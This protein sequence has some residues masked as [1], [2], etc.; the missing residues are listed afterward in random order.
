MFLRKFV[1][2]SPQ[3]PTLHLSVSSFLAICCS[4]PKKKN[5]CIM[6][7]SFYFN[8][9]FFIY[10]VHSLCCLFQFSL[11]TKKRKKNNQKC[12]VCFQYWSPLEIKSAGKKETIFEKENYFCEFRRS[13]H[14]VATYQKKKFIASSDVNSQKKISCQKHH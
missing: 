5:I 11:P 3:S 14:S 2:T 8:F 7:C 6:E 9:Y 1:F 10:F 12:L 13:S 4:N